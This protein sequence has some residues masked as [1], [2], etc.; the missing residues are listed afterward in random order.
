MN[1]VAL[2]AGG[3]DVASFCTT[4]RGVA[5]LPPGRYRLPVRSTAHD[6]RG[7]VLQET[8]VVLRDKP[9]TIRLSGGR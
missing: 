1:T 8:E 7:K 4:G 5:K 6:S 3:V 9:V 2:A